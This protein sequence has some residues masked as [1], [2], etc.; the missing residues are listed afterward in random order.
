MGIV[1]TI[2]A[3]IGLIVVL[4]FIFE[5]TTRTYRRAE[6]TPWGRALCA[7]RDSMG[8]PPPERASRVD[9]VRYESQ[10]NRRVAARRLFRVLH[11]AVA[12][13]G[14]RRRKDHGAESR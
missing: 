1:W 9:W 14:R 11:G 4:Q 13:R 6:R 3:I 7:S 8:N 2:L 12:K 5:T 10:E